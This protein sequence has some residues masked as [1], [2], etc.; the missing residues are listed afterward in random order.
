MMFHVFS[1]L[2]TRK[3]RRVIIEKNFGILQ[4]AAEIAE[5]AE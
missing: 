1:E 2:L 3:Q 4:E 5:G